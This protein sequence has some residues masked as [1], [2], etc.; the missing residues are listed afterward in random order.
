MKSIALWTSIFFVIVFISLMSIRIVKSITRK[1][2]ALKNIIFSIDNL[3]YTTMFLSFVLTEYF[4]LIA[5]DKLL[6]GYKF[7]SELKIFAYIV[8]FLTGVFVSIVISTVLV[9]SERAIG[10]GNLNYTQYLTVGIIYLL[11]AGIDFGTLAGGFKIVASNLESAKVRAIKKD[12]DPKTLFIVQEK[13]KLY[14]EKK[15]ELARLDNL[16]ANP[17]AIKASDDKI[18]RLKRELVWC[19]RTRKVCRTTK[20]LL[21]THLKELQLSKLPELK[22]KRDKV[23]KESKQLLNEYEKVS[24]EITH[25][26]NKKLLSVKETKEKITLFGYIFAF[27]LVLFNLVSNI[28]RSKLEF[29]DNP[30]FRESE[31]NEIESIKSAPVEISKEYEPIHEDSTPRLLE[32]S[33]I[34]SL[35]KDAMKEYAEEMGMSIPKNTP[36]SV[37]KLNF[38]RDAIREKM[39]EILAGVDSKLSFKIGNSSLK[40]LIEKHRLEVTLWVKEN[41]LS[42]TNI[43]TLE[44]A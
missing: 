15:A 6:E 42:W 41:Y 26:K 8:V 27:S 11:V 25:D 5:G 10:E 32:K 23:F 31:V 1:D 21:D 14:K 16:I 12:I 13:Q 38:P 22:A 40:S 2:S 36:I 18:K 7:D 24:R 28:A 17:T 29:P 3:R 4:G 35:V 44:A 33:E 34:E 9:H 43:P 19:K 39:K 37:V 20:S 30:L